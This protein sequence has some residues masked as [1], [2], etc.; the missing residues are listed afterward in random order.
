MI[1]ATHSEATRLLTF[2]SHDRPFNDESPPHIFPCHI[3]ILLGYFTSST[4][5]L[6][7]LLL[8]SL[9]HFTQGYTT[10]CMFYAW[11]MWA[12]FSPF[13]L[14]GPDTRLKVRL[15]TDHLHSRGV[16]CVIFHIQWV[17]RSN[18]VVVILLRV[19]GNH[20]TSP[21][22]AAGAFEVIMEHTVN[23]NCNLLVYSLHLFR[24]RSFQSVARWPCPL[25]L[26]GGF[27]CKASEI[28]HQKLIAPT[29]ELWKAGFMASTMQSTALDIE[30]RGPVNAGQPFLCHYHHYS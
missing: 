23:N 5:A 25:H 27:K 7:H 6:I 29:C 20:L 30:R 17:T 8:L 9:K 14:S 4:W 15:S 18:E 10:M 26:A 13:H 12:L 2:S 22:S 24:R 11:F 3:W 21:E 19:A 16:K 28:T 1:E